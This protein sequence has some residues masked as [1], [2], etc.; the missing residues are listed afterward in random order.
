MATTRKAKAGKKGKP[1][2]KAS[3]KPRQKVRKKARLTA[4]GKTRRA[5]RGAEPK[6]ARKRGTRP[7]APAKRQ[8][9]PK[10]T[11]GM[12][13]RAAGSAALTP[14]AR[15]VRAIPAAPTPTAATA[16]PPA[17]GDLRD[18]VIAVLRRRGYDVSD[19][20]PVDV[21]TDVA[22]GYGRGPAAAPTWIRFDTS[23]ALAEGVVERFETGDRSPDLDRR[24]HRPQVR[25][26]VVDNLEQ[27]G[28]TSS[29]DEA[30]REVLTSLCLGTW[31]PA[32]MT[33]AERDGVAS[34]LVRW[35]R[36]GR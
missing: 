21:L 11:A 15:A 30:A 13:A 7:K 10:A 6:V 1:T 34:F 28:L 12:R 27:L 14:K 25:S 4:A 23:Q 33:N 18:A 19:A 24:M 35:Y 3:Q 16:P 26:T 29:T 22:R 32:T 20:A 9:L 5:K 17:A 8:A 31:E 2:K 36:D